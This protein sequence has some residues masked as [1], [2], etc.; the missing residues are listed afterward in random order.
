MTATTHIQVRDTRDQLIDLLSLGYTYPLRDLTVEDEQLTVAFS[1]A[2]KIP[3]L[4]SQKDVL[5]QLHHKRKLVERTPEGEQGEGIPVELPGNGKTIYLETYKIKEDIT[6]EVFAIKPLSGNETYLHQTATV[7]VGLDTSLKAWIHAPHL[8]QQDSAGTD[9]AA[10]VVHYGESVEVEVENSQEGVDYHLVAVKAGKEETI[11]VADV[12]G[13][14]HNIILTTE[15][16]YEDVDVR[17]RAT[18]TFDPGENRETQTAL[19]DVVLPLKARANTELTLSVAPATIV[20]YGQPATLTI[21]NSQ[22]S[23]QY[24]LYT[25]VV[26]DQDFV[27][28]PDPDADLLRVP[29]AG[30]AEVQ[31]V[32]PAWQEV[33]T[34]PE[35]Y[36]PSGSPQP[37][38]GTDLSFSLPPL[39]DDSLIIVQAAKAHELADAS[40]IRKVVPTSVQLKQTAV[41][42]T[43]PNPNPPLYLTVQ[44]EAGTT[45]TDG[46]LQV[47]DGQPGI[48]YF[49]R[50]DPQG[51]PLGQPAYF[52]KRDDADDTN[53]KGVGQLVMG[54]DFV[55]TRPFS[56]TITD[57]AA[58]PPQPPILETGPLP[59]NTVL[60]IEAVKAQTRLS[61]PL[62]QTALIAALPEIRPEENIVNQGGTAK[63][64]V[65]ASHEGDKYQPFLNGESVR[66]ARY[67]NGEDLSF[68]TDGLTEDTDFE[69]WVTRPDDADHLRVDRVVLLSISVSVTEPDPAPPPEPD[70][71]P[72]PEPDPAPSPEP[73][74][75]PPLDNGS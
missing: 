26:P 28:Q 31:I 46:S 20:D 13:D 44:I 29:V 47:F 12:R 69:M 36:Q 16:V 52:H 7:K 10:C 66:R 41:F 62:N 33:W 21:A 65:L 64:L 37:G 75:A 35:G 72:S 23:A 56:T 9:T 61:A 22:Q 53:N 15:P 17:V 1:V 60:H 63:L 73:D 38:T 42:L 59:A 51:Q 71:S 34:A 43:R 32:K 48:F 50:S 68:S 74:P 58:T 25:R 24:Q 67:G 27:H 45:E 39:T 8:Q 6:F 2:A 30:E 19:L 5:Y 18:K 54:V 11:S 3:I 57:P 4:N 40:G 55:V 14:L 49:F 70:P